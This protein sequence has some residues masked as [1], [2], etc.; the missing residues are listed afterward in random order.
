VATKEDRRVKRKIQTDNSDETVH[1][2]SHESKSKEADS[3][4]NFPPSSVVT[5]R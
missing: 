2:S 3:P 1:E 5:L 4:D